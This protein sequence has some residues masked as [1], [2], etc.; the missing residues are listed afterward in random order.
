MFKIL[1]YCMARSFWKTAHSLPWM[2]TVYAFARWPLIH[3]LQQLSGKHFIYSQHGKACLRTS[4]GSVAE[5]AWAGTLLRR[6]LA[7]ES[8]ANVISV[9]AQGPGTAEVELLGREVLGM[10]RN[11][12]GSD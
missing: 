7:D 10:S 3:Q 1:Q 8:L 6:L 12:A 2:V 11:L 4:V 9:P 5:Q